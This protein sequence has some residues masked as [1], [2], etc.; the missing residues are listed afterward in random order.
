MTLQRQ[1]SRPVFETPIERIFRKTMKRPMTR[2]ER[3]WLH[4]KLSRPEKNQ[5][6]G[7]EQK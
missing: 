3:R 7:A 1:H 6:G 5:T 2:A 4:L